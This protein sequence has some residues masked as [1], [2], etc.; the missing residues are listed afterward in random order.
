[1]F[2]HVSVSPK[3]SG[4][5]QRSGDDLKLVATEEVAKADLLEI[6]ATTDF[7]HYFVQPLWNRTDSLVKAVALIEAAPSW[8]LGLQT[9]KMVGAR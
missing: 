9:H 7:S 3:S 6:E 2:D 5:V 1:M 4:F 8:R